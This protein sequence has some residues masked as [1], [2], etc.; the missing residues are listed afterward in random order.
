MNTPDLTLGERW[1]DH[2]VTGITWIQS[3]LG[4][5]DVWVAPKSEPTPETLIRVL[6]A[7]ASGCFRISDDFQ[8]GQPPKPVLVSV[9]PLLLPGTD[10]L[11]IG[12]NAET[13]RSRFTSSPIGGVVFEDPI[14]ALLAA[15]AVSRKD[16]PRVAIPR[17]RD[18]TDLW[19]RVLAVADAIEKR[20][21]QPE[22][23]FGP[24]EGWIPPSKMPK[25][26]LLSVRSEQIAALRT[27][28][29]QALWISRPPKVFELY[30]P[31]IGTQG[32]GPKRSGNPQTIRL[33]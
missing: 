27:R 33:S 14:W 5:A 7:L 18:A 11:L 26:E 25:F 16:Q 20:R 24:I 10:Y 15:Y 17:A 30:Q 2:Y 1:R 32:P 3:L 29:I 28:G 13:P 9:P 31:P 21:Y 23:F 22:D 6:Q 8:V 19:N 12:L 4:C